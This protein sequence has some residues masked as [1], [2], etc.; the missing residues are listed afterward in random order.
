MIAGPFK[1]ASEKCKPF[2]NSMDGTRV[3]RAIELYENEYLVG[4]SFPADVRSFPESHSLPKFESREQV[5]KYVLSV[6][7]KG[8]YAAEAYSLDLVD[9]TGE[10]PD[11]MLGS[12]PEATSGVTA[13]HLYAVMLE[14]ERKAAAH[15]VS[16]IGHRTDH[17]VQLQIL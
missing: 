14:V 6:R 15:N 9:T 11:I 4:K 13:S 16:L 2:H 1:L 5:Q 7:E 8:S 12:F 17:F 10:S 3:I